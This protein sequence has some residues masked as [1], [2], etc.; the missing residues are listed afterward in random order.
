VSGG[1]TT[2]LGRPWRTVSRRRTI[3]AL[4]I[5]GLVHAT[6]LAACGLWI[7][8]PPPT[9]PNLAIRTDW[10]ESQKP[11]LTPFEALPVDSAADEDEEG[12]T[13]DGQAIF[14][15]AQGVVGDALALET[16]VLS[17]LEA[18]GPLAVAALPSQT[19]GLSGGQGRGDAAGQGNGGESGAGDG[20]ADGGRFFGLT[21]EGR[22]VVYV[23]DASRSMNHP[24]PGPMKTRFGRVKLELVRSISGMRPEQEFFIVYFN[25]RAWPM[26]ATSMKLAVRSAQQKYLRWAVEAK[27]SGQT[28]P[29]DALLAALRLRP[30]VI[31]FLTD[32]A[33]HPN[34]V[35][36]V[37]TAN[38][39]ARV[40]IHTIGFGDDEG[41]SLLQDIAF[42]NW[43][44]YQ[45]IPGDETEPV[46]VESR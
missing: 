33:F 42:Q 35:E 15:H 8:S 22:R 18:S 41:E 9:R 12:G 16:A 31:Y 1:L 32:G 10:N 3:G 45:F 43:G 5:S 28:D 29:Q 20:E 44:S 17:M 34:V 46:S 25:D 14:R 30:D 39:Q 19:V 13:S 37:R 4:A 21:T 6:L 40:R 38:Q 7:F 36:L 27:A 2:W 11:D 26:P 23:V 24:H